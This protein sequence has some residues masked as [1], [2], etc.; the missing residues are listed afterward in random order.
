MGRVRAMRHSFTTSTGKMAYKE[1][2]IL[3]IR[4]HNKGYYTLCLYK[5]N[6]RK[7][8]YVHRLVAECFL[9]NPNCLPCVN[10][11]DNNPANNCVENLEWCSY[12]DNTAHAKRQGRLISPADMGYRKPKQPYRVRLID[13]TIIG[14][15]KDSKSAMAAI[16]ENPLNN[17]IRNKARDGKPYKNKYIFEKL[18]RIP[19]YSIKEHG[20]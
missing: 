14:V 16:G 3:S 13:G 19:N 12:K 1:E 15:F 6:Q 7:Q 4:K 10:H 5:K 9:E 2:R 18:P 20:K 8:H 11:I 17:I